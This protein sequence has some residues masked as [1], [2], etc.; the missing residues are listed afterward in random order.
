M[1]SFP[2]CRHDGVSL[3]DFRCDA[4]QHEMSAQ[5]EIARRLAR[6]LGCRFK[7]EVR[8]DDAHAGRI[9][10]A[11]PNTPITSRPPAARLRE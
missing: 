11:V 3:V 1:S 8:H 9:G 7:G 2:S 5:R 6:V 4:P 10:Y